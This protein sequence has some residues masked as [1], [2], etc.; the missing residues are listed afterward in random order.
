MNHTVSY[1]VKV[2]RGEDP[3]DSI[4]GLMEKEYILIILQ[5][6]GFFSFLFYSTPLS[7]TKKQKICRT[8]KNGEVHCNIT[9]YSQ[10]NNI[11]RVDALKHIMLFSF[12]K[13]T[14]QNI[15]FFWF[16]FSVVKIG[17]YW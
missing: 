16:F 13:Y 10:I 17:N 4:T 1:L 7:F 9:H 12:Y 15:L 11:I 14:S 6:C 3:F 5:S 2:R 8:N